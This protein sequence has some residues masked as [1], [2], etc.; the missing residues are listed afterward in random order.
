MKKLIFISLAFLSSI[1]QSQDF[2]PIGAQWI[3]T[4]EYCFETPTYCGYYY[5][6]VE[7]DTI[8]NDK[9]CRKINKTYTQVT[10][11]NKDT[12]FYL[13]G[14]NRQVFLYEAQNNSFRKLYDFNLNAGDTLAVARIGETPPFFFKKGQSTPAFVVIVDSTST[15][16]T[17]GFQLKVQYTSPLLDLVGYSS[18]FYEFSNPTIEHI[19]NTDQFFGHP[20]NR[21]QAG[22]YGYLVCYSENGQV[23]YGSPE[24]ITTSITNPIEREWNI[25]PNPAQDLL[26]IQFENEF[27]T[28]VL[29]SDL[30]G[31]LLIKED[32]QTGIQNVPVSLNRLAA[33][34]YLIHIQQNGKRIGSKLFVKQ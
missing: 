17:N 19:G 16:E 34:T 24:C 33:G 13:Y 26:F 23:Y 1:L 2:A 20:V 9:V 25:Y 10:Q 7:K 8:I 27:P 29:I 4:V 11:F 30:Q 14:E 12:T 21:V 32:Y 6:N 22:F 28:S 18:S 5:L 31:R 15:Y 3:Y